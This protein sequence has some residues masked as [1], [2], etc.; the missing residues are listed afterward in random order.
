MTGRQGPFSGKP[1]PLS[2]V[3]AIVTDAETRLGLYV[4]RSL[5]RA[6]CR[7]TALS[8]RASGT[9]IGFSSRYAADHIRLPPGDYWETLPSA[10]EELGPGHDLL[11]PIS[12]FSIAVVATSRDRIEP[13]LSFYIPELEAFRLASDKRSTTEAGRRAGVPIPEMVRSPEPAEVADWAEGVRDRLPLVVKF[14]DD[15]RSGS[16][17][18]SERYRIVRTPEELAREYL[19]MHDIA[20]YPLIQEYVEGD[21]FGFFTVM[22]PQGEA[23]GTFCHRR[24]REYP[25]SG[26][27]STLCESHHDP[28]LVEAGITLLKALDWRGVAMVEF[29]QNRSTGEYKL[30]EINPRFWGSLPLAIHCGMDFPLYQAQIA[31]GMEPT[32]PVG[33]PTGRRMRFFFP[34]LLAVREE[35]RSG[36]KWQVFRRYLGELLD[37]SIKDGIFEA[38]DPRPLFTYLAE[39][40]ER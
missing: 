35:W 9:V 16:W 6:G 30:L 33:Y 23:V 21:G 3:R 13:L 2:G 10:L 38:D 34:D 11:M 26:G 18:P 15:E 37:L 19:R 14:S 36:P 12:A 8:N 28:E 31:M 29:K 20:A 32:P 22:G 4:I 7:V 1:G 40:V 27:P 17:A 24:L 39:K 5:G 25:T